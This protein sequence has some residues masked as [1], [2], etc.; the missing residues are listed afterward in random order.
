MGNI[1][2]NT[3]K[4]RTYQNA[5]PSISTDPLAAYEHLR[6]QGPACPI[7]SV[8]G[9]LMWIVARYDG[10][11]SV[12]GDARFANNPASVPG[13]HAPLLQ[14][15]AM[16][17]LGLDEEL[18]PY[19]TDTLLDSD[20]KDHSRLR[21]LVTPSFSARRVKELGPRIE[22]ITDD[23]IDALPEQGTAGVTDLLEHFAYPLPI[24]VIGELVGVPAV[25]RP[26]W[27]RWTHDLSFN[28]QALGQTLRPLVDY[29][30]DLVRRRCAE[31][32]EDVI[33]DLIQARNADGDRL[34]ERELVT[35][36][37]SLVIAGHDTTANFIANSIWA[38]LTHPDQLAL[39]RSDPGLMPQA[40]QELLRWCGPVLVSR[41]RYAT[42]DVDLGWGTF[43]AGDAVTVA[44]SGG[45]Y[46]PRAFEDPGILDIARQHDVRGE[47]HVSFGAGPHYC[48]GA[49]LARREAEIALS[50]LLDRH[51]A[52]ALAVPAEQLQWHAVSGMRKL[53]ELPVRL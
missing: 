22:R 12:L 8:E 13:E 35:M 53:A 7:R 32:G 2:R 6:E 10:V 17:R 46:D 41:M 29:T 18:I 5:A 33:S 47:A 14:V 31:P 26:A 34:S 49:T 45:N 24:H 44:L 9:S 51:P 42:E 16:R 23:L 28:Q 43:Q 21:R 30:Y 19:L 38:L 27:L 37:L 3:A 11:R 39:L 48:L 50:R 20:G 52:L 40:V 1:R 25:D 36:V 15:N 4:N